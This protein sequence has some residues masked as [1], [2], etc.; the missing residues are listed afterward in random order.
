MPRQ[1]HHRSAPLLKWFARNQNLAQPFDAELYRVAGPRH[2]TAAAIVSGMGAFLV[3][4]RWNPVGEMRVVYLSS[5]P[6][7]ATQEALEHF[8]YNRI[9]ISHGLPKVIVA[10]HVKVERFLDLTDAAISAS[11]PVAMPQLLAEDWRARLAK[12]LESASQAVGWAAFT[13]G[14]QGFKVPSKPDP[15]GTNVLVFPENLTRTCRL[16]VLNAD[17]LEKLGKTM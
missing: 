6:E 11:L 15:K 3:G 14:F 10:V 5:E 1:L 9:P 16:E 8:R 4:G 13:A 12:N 2:T 7:T 17:A